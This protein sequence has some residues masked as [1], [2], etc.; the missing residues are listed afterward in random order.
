M[1]PGTLDH[2]RFVRMNGVSLAP[3]DIEDVNENPLVGTLFHDAYLEGFFD[4][5][6]Y[7]PTS[8]EDTLEELVVED[9]EKH[10][11]KAS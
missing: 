6:G 9:F 2:L 3:E 4:E 11:K 1:K 10:P 5:H 7:Y 8:G